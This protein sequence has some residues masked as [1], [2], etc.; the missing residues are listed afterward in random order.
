MNN[1]LPLDVELLTSA[2]KNADS[3]PYCCPRGVPDCWLGTATGRHVTCE[4]HPATDRSKCSG[5]WRLACR[6]TGKI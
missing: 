5:K 6:C 2:K 4:F 3:F 1:A